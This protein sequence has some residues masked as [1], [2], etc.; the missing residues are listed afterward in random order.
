MK[1]DNNNRNKWKEILYENQMGNF[2]QNLKMFYFHIRFI[3]LSF[4]ECKGRH[5]P[6]TIGKIF[7]TQQEKYI[8]C[9]LRLDLEDIYI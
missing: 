6:I 3:C 7:N 8:I 9:A 5:N 2:N 4:I 1:C